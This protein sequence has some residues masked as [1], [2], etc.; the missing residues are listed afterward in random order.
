MG[1]TGKEGYGGGGR[2]GVGWGQ[3]LHG[4]GPLHR[5]MHRDEPG[6]WAEGT[7]GGRPVC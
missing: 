2:G 5:L 7:G 1:E 6:C 4:A 3:G